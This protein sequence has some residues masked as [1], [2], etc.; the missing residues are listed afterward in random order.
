MLGLLVQR[1]SFSPKLPRGRAK[2]V[3]PP[4][5]EVQQQTSR[6]TDCLGLKLPVS[7]Q[8]ATSLS[9]SVGHWLLW[10]PRRVFPVL[11]CQ[12]WVPEPVVATHAPVLSDAQWGEGQESGQ[13]E[14][15]SAVVTEG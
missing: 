11:S 4:Q 10:A 15:G 7:G 3:T 5:A 6:P 12:T 8:K 9:L 2:R 1:S 13:Q 14:A